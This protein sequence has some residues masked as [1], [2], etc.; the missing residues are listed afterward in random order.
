MKGKY[1]TEQLD[2]F[3]LQKLVLSEKFCNCIIEGA[4]DRTY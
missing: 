3:F 1:M 4:I 2:D